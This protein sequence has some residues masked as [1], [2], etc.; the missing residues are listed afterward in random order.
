MAE[1][2]SMTSMNSSCLSS[3]INE[4]ALQ[5]DSDVDAEDIDYDYVFYYINK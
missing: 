1:S 4:L 3:N 2:S 5:E